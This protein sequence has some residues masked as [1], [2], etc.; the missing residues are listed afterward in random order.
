MALAMRL[1]RGGR[2][3]RPFYRIVV[4]DKR[5]PRDGRY[6]ERLGTFN[7]LLAKDNEQRLNM[8]EERIKYWLGQGAQPSD[9]VARFLGQAGI[10]PMPEQNNNPKK[11]EPSEKTKMRVAEK[12]EKKKAAEEAAKTA[13]ETPAE[14][15]P[16]E[17]APATED[18][19]AEAPAEEAAAEAPAEEAKADDAP[20]E[21]EK[22]AE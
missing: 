20:A 15:A 13:A 2:K 7:P 22:K 3:N 10:I 18:A 14:E 19:A 17:E 21:E 9:R 1:S 11:G 4:A 8:N 6:I 16:A 5:M 12:E